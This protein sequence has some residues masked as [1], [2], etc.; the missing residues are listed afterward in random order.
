MAELV[1]TGRAPGG[2]LAD[3]IDVRLLRTDFDDVRAAMAR[4]HDGGALSALDQARDLDVRLREIGTERDGLRA[5]VNDISKAVGMLRRDGNV[6]EAEEKQAE[7]K[8]IGETEKHLAR[9]FDEGARGGVL[10]L[11]DEADSLFGRRTQVRSSV[12]RYANLEINYLLQRIESYPGVVVL[13][14]NHD[15]LIDEAFKRRL[16]F[17]VHFPVP[18]A[19]ERAAI[20][21]G[22]IPAA[23]PLQGDLKIAQLAEEFEMSGGH[24]RNAV[25]RAAFLAAT[26]DGGLSHEVLARAARQEYRALGRLIRDEGAPGRAKERNVWR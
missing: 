9:I 1:R 21:E 13:T 25:I 17:R 26:G 18:G 3:V 24:I 5:Q 19:A 10:L 22:L 14:S 12:D 6:A 8:F 2:S 15:H 16:Q 11:F 4:R 23:C 20:W 7:S